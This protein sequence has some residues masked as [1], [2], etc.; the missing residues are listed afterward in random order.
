[1]TGKCSGLS[2]RILEMNDLVFYT[3][4]MPH[5]LNLEVASSCNI[6][7]GQNVMDK[8]QEISNFLECQPTD[9]FF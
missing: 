8:M 9:N 4:F 5:I 1:M 7:S 2:A 3:H 6:Q